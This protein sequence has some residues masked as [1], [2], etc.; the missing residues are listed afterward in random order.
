ELAAGAHTYSEEAQGN[1]LSFVA[2]KQVP[3]HHYARLAVEQSQICVRTPFLDNDLVGLAFQAPTESQRNLAPSLRLIAEGNPGLGQI[4]TDRGVSYPANL[5]TSRVHRSVEE[6]LTKAEYA[7]D[8]GMP[9]WLA[10]I[11]R[12]LQP[13][14]LERL[15]LGRQ[16]FCHFRT[17]YRHQL[18]GYVKEVLLDPLSRSRPHV[19]SS[20]LEPLVNAHVSGIRNYTVEI[21]KLLSLELLHRTFLDYRGCDLL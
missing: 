13:L 14:R 17:W 15:F 16:K 7:Y 10:R 3:W 21:H 2:F 20:A 11:D 1:Q 6:F 8:Y 18:A 9:N 4:P 5:I 19:N 12:V